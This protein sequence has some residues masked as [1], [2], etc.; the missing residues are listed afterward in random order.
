MQGSN[1]PRWTSFVRGQE[2][3]ELDVVPS[4]YGHVYSYP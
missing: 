4:T 2:K 3:Q 1:D